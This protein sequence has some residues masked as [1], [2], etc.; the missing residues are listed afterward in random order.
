MLI[1][2]NFTKIINVLFILG[3]ILTVSPFFPRPH[4]NEFHHKLGL[5]VEIISTFI[6]GVLM[7]IKVKLVAVLN[8][9]HEGVLRLLINNIKK[10][11]S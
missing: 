6:L 2:C 11:K 7:H 8:I 5:K 3:F 10:L 4:G 1:S 9:I